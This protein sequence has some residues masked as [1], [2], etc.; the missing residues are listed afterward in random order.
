VTPKQKR[1][2][3]EYLID[4][5]A[6]QAAIR[7]G[8]K[9]KTAYSAGQRLLKKVEEVQTAIDIAIKEREKKSAV[10]AEYVLTNLQEVVERCLQSAPV[11]NTK[12]QQVYD[13]EG[14]ALWEFNAPGA[15]KAL[16]LLGKHLGMFSEKVQVGGM[17]GKEIVVRWKSS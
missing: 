3:E 12:G 10:T 6:T 2:V 11:V 15:N 17:E 5:N 4:L 13:E 9:E 14:N 7:A 8:F 16:E 1:F